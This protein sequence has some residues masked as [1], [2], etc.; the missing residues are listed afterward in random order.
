MLSTRH[1]FLCQRLQVQIPQIEFRARCEVYPPGIE[2]RTFRV[3]FR[4][5][6]V[7]Y[8]CHHT[9]TV[10]LLLQNGRVLFLLSIII[11]KVVDVIRAGS[12]TKKQTASDDI[13]AGLRDPNDNGKIRMF[14]ACRVVFLCGL[15]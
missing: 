13:R 5:A 8:K 12:T 9:I 1:I 4:W 7:L 10:R 6:R 3:V 2:L 11:D 15:F 14:R